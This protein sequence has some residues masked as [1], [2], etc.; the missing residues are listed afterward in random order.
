[1]EALAAHVERWKQWLG[2]DAEDDVGD[3]MDE[4]WS[5]ANEA[6]ATSL[7]RMKDERAQAIQKAVHQARMEWAKED[8]AE[9]DRLK[10]EQRA[11]GIHRAICELESEIDPCHPI[12]ERLEQIEGEERRQAEGEEHEN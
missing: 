2:Q 8:K 1:M 5:I 7:A 10:A 4:G 11:E 12:I 6:P 9:L 3:W